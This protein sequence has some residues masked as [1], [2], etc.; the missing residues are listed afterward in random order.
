MLQNLPY[1]NS[2]KIMYSSLF[3]KD[4]YVFAVVKQI[5]WMIVL[6]AVK[7]HYVQIWYIIHIYSYLIYTLINLNDSSS[8]HYELSLSLA[9]YMVK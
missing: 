8:I 2:K 4:D 6:Y 7:V 5:G 9:L 1:F 3:L